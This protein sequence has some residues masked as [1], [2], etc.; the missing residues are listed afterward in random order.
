MV[1]WISNP[2]FIPFMSKFKDCVLVLED[3]EK[4][5]SHRDNGNPNANALSNLLNLGDGL[6]SDAFSINILCTFNANLQKIDDALLRKGRLIAR[7]EFKELE[8]PKAQQ[9]ADKL[10]K[11]IRVEKPMTLTDI[12][13]AESMKFENKKGNRI[14]FAYA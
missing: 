10:E 12:Y 3:C 11:N 13:N 6:L 5:L 9:L 2:E 1:E 14:G 7:Y 4:L 8:I